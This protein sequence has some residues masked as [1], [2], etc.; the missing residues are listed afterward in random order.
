M[1]NGRQ[2][3]DDEGRARLI[4][5]LLEPT[6]TQAPDAAEPP[7]DWIDGGPGPVPVSR[8]YGDPFYAKTDGLAETEHVYLR[9]NRLE[10]R[11]LADG[12]VPE[13]TEPDGLEPEGP[14]AFTIGELGF[15]TGL[16]SLVTWRLWTHCAP[17]GAMLR[18]VSFEEAPLGR[19]TMARALAPFGAVAPGAAMLLGGWP[20]RPPSE[21]TLV[22]DLGNLHLEVRI[23]DARRRLPDWA[24]EKPVVDAWFLDGFAP[25]RNP[26]MW[27]PNLLTTVG[28]LTRPGGSFATYSAAGAVR[29]ALLAAGFA[30]ERLPGFGAKREMLAGRMIGQPLEFGST[31]P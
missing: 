26:E 28:R 1:S 4:E 18:F 19:A 6:P 9:G 8:R 29:R 24:R 27:E 16:A 21:G 7:L 17:P 2:E 31:T 5:G 3:R 23:G 13:G 25:A 22:L 12:T 14:W 11:W 15:G 30:V 10:E 20:D